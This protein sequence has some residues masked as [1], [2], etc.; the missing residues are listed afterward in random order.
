MLLARNPSNFEA[1]AKNIN[2]KGGQA[3]GISADVT[4]QDSLK[5]AFYQI[6]EKFRGARCAA[7]VFNAAGGFVRKPL[8]DVTLEEFSSG[9]EVNV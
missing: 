2:D 4:S 1:L 3:I 7:A 6:D 8:L 5:Q 9:F